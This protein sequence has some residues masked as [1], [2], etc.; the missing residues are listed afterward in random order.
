MLEDGRIRAFGGMER[1]V[2]TSS[3]GDR[4]VDPVE[5]DV[6][7]LALTYDRERFEVAL[8]RR[9]CELGSVEQIA[10]ALAHR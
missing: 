4:G 1:A 2:A 8:V 9:V 5:L 7:G 6:R 10:D 3:L